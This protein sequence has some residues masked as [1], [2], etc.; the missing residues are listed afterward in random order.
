[1]RPETTLMVAREKDGC[2]LAVAGAVIDDSVCLLRFSVASYHP[3]RWALHDYLVQLLIGRGVRCLLAEG[4]GA[5]GALGFAPGI[6]HYQHLLGYE[7]RHVVPVARTVVATG[8]ELGEDTAIPEI[9]AVAG[10]VG[11][12]GCN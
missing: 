12:R 2:P 11:G 4:G 7:L 3:A 1:M 6:Q 5:F 10:S 8:S 9:C